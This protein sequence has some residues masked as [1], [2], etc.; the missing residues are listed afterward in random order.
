MAKSKS[1]TVEEIQAD[2]ATNR[3]RMAASFGDFIEEVKPKN[4]AKRGV[5]QARGFVSDEF[6]AAKS[7][8]KD[9]SGWRTDRLIAIGGAI[10]GVVVFVVTVNVIA[11]RRT[12]A[13]E[14]TG[15]RALERGA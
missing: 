7:Q 12:H 3:A 5:D 11:G 6:Q 15:R 1:R 4:V 10:L 2:L 9:E 13:I 8:I 14:A